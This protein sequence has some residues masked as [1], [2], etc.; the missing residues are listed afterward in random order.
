MRKLAV[1]AAGIAALSFTAAA[2]AKLTAVEQKWA[3]PMITVWNQQNLALHVVLQ[4]ATA[5][6]A[7]VYGTPNNKKLTVVLNTFVVCGPAIKKA[8]APPSPRLQTFA[9]ALGTACTQDTAG[10]RDFAKTVGAVRAKKAAQAQTLLKQGVSKFK[11]GSAALTQAYRS[12][13][14]IG[15]KN[16]FTA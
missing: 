1:L 15:G 11:L 14:A 8:G 7:L 12:L 13:I 9:T 4:A 2:D 16:V 5:K 10:A 6:N 3:K